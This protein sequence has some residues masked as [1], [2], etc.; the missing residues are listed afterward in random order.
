M[1]RIEH[2][3]LALFRK[4]CGDTEATWSTMSREEREDA[5]EWVQTVTQALAEH[6][7]ELIPI[8]R[9]PERLSREERSLN[10]K[11]VQSGVD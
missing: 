3:A 5:M 1:E 11:S 8:P 10:H 6:D 4:V 7:A 9:Y 2:A